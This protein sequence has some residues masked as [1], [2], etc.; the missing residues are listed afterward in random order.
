MIRASY[1]STFIRSIYDQLRVYRNINHLSDL[2]K[3]LLQPHISISPPLAS[4]QILPNTHGQ[5]NA[6]FNFLTN[7]THD[8]D[9]TKKYIQTNKQ[10]CKTK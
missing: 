8:L 1:N 7:T 6:Y 5:N 4:P 10:K 9:N 3:T 2:I